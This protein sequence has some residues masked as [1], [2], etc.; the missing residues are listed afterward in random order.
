M[1][2]FD[3]GKETRKTI[4]KLTEKFIAVILVLMFASAIM[5]IGLGIITHL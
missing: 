1:D 4:A 3:F 2:T 5:Y